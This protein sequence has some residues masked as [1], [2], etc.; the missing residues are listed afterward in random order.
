M[1][2]ITLRVWCGVAVCCGV[3]HG[4]FVPGRLHWLHQLLCCCVAR[5]FPLCFCCV[6][7]FVVLR[8]VVGFGIV[9][10]PVGVKVTVGYAMLCPVV[11]CRVMWC[12]GVSCG[13]MLC[14]VALWFV[15]LCCTVVRWLISV[16]FV[17]WHCFVA[18][19]VVVC[20]LA[21]CCF[22][23]MLVV[24]CGAVLHCV[25]LCFAVVLY[26]SFVVSWRCVCCGVV[27]RRVA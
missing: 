21:A 16:V 12:G 5:F 14:C 20:C 25:V 26:G 4:V 17:L 6:A 1:V 10:C 19:F 18:R 7:R 23:G 11:P 27:L 9:F 3:S 24:S 22:S 8:C 13:G 2:V 15:A